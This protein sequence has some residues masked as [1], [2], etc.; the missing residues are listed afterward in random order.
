MK[1]QIQLVLNTNKATTKNI[2][3]S[4]FNYVLH[5]CELLP[6]IKKSHYQLKLK[7]IREVVENDEDRIPEINSLDNPIYKN[8]NIYLK[9]LNFINLKNELLINTYKMAL[10]RQTPFRIHFHRADLTAGRFYYDKN[11]SDGP[12]LETYV[13]SL[14]SNDGNWK[15]LI[16]G[17]V[18]TGRIQTTFNNYAAGK[19]YIFDRSQNDNNPS[20]SYLVNT[21]NEQTNALFSLGATIVNFPID[22]VIYEWYNQFEPYNQNLTI[23]NDF[24]FEEPTNDTINL[25]LEFRDIETNEIITNTPNNEKYPDFSFT[26]DIC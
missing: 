11:I 24:T 17:A 4:Q 3:N 25:S 1:K 14:N 19:K 2:F 12:A 16:I 6:K 7:E 26:F 13:N 20:V 9:G 10:P 18:S 8:F 23:I 15:M 22:I 21:K 5:K